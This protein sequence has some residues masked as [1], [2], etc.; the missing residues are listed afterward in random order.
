MKLPLGDKLEIMVRDG[1]LMIGVGMSFIAAIGLAGKLSESDNSLL[2]LLLSISFFIFGLFLI[3]QS[4][5]K[6]K[7]IWALAADASRVNGILEPSRT[8]SQELDGTTFYRVVYSYPFAGLSYTH[9]VETNYP[10][11]YSSQELIFIQ[12]SRPANAVFA[13]DLPTVVRQKLLSAT[14]L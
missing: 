6:H 5:D 2:E 4:I 9:C 7:A 1:R 14:S 13:A 12:R 8:T 10:E 3:Y 11:K